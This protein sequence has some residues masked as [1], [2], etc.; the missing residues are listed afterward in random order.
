[1]NMVGVNHRATSKVEVARG[2]KASEGDLRLI[3]ELFF[4]NLDLAWAQGELVVEVVHEHKRFLLVLVLVVGLVEY[5]HCVKVAET[6]QGILI[7]GLDHVVWLVKRVL[8]ELIKP[9]VIEK[10]SL[11]VKI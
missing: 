8:L 3:R 10:G 5:I 7:E 11:F 2:F 4:I 9:R 1:V 6:L